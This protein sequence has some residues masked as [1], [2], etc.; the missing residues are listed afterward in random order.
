MWLLV[1]FAFNMHGDVVA[2][3]HLPFKTSE[4]CF[5]AQLKMGTLNFTGPDWPLESIVR[6]VC[7]RQ[8]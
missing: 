5:E 7:V 8:K 1:L 6:G 4:A 2:I 3:D